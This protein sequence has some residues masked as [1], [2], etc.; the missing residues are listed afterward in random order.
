MEYPRE[1]AGVATSRVQSENL[2]WTGFAMITTSC[3]EE[4]M[5]TALKWLNYGFSEEGLMYKNFGTEGV[6][7]TLDANGDPQWTDV[8]TGNSGGITE[9]LKKYTATWQAPVASVQLAHH[10][11]IKNNETAVDAV[12]KWIENSDTAKHLVPP[13][14]LT[15]E[16]S[17]IYSDKMNAINTRVDEM[18]LKFLTGDES[19]DNFDSFVEE[20]YAMG[21]QECLDIQQAAYARFM[22]R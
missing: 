5:I 4:E 9:A 3:S 2:A 16:E 8:I 7:Y 17:V 18:A 19:L 14:A 15:S 12:Y 21:L 10:V 6:T 20:I 1:A 22:E 11:K 13:L